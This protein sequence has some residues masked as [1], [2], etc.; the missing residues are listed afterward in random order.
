ME[1]EEDK[2]LVLED[3][4]PETPETNEEIEQ[5]QTDASNGEEQVQEEVVEPEKKYTQN[6]VDNIINARFARE[7]RNY[8]RETEKYKE[9]E[10]IMKTAL[11]ATDIDDVINKSKEFY[12]SNGIDIPEYKPTLNQEEEEMLGNGFADKI[13]STGDYKFMDQEASRIAGI[14]AEK[15]SVRDNIMFSKLCEALVENKN[16]KIL[17]DKGIDVNILDDQNFKKFREKLNYKTPITEAVE[18]FNKL[19]TVPEKK[20]KPYSVG[21]VK[22]NVKVNEIKEYYSPEDFDKLTEADLNNPEIMKRVDESRTKWY[23]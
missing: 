13:I 22:N 11:N 5:A 8:E 2:E 10:S 1:N 16:K 15:R 14:P 23:Q 9:L 6:D 12:K 7:K 19:N 18:M 4:V 17:S 3:G 21:S 20:E